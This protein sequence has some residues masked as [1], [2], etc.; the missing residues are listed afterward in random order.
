[1]VRLIAGFKTNPVS[2]AVYCTRLLNADGDI[3]FVGGEMCDTIAY[4]VSPEAYKL[5]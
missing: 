4:Y 2:S 5:M 1:M 3:L